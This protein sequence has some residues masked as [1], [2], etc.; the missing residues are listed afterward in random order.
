MKNRKNNLY[1]ILFITFLFSF[2]G[3][4]LYF[5]NSRDDVTKE[6]IINNDISPYQLLEINKEGLYPNSYIMAFVT[7]IVDGDTIVV[8]YKKSEHRV[9]L[10][11][12]D[13]P[14]S[15]KQGV[16]VQP[17]AKDALQFTKNKLIKKQVKLVFEKSLKDKYDRLLA[18]VFLTRNEYFNALLVELGY[19]R[20]E[21]LKPNDT[22]KDYF[23][24]RQNHAIQAKLGVWSLNAEK[25][26]FV[27]NNYGEYVPRYW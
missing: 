2:V 10:L 3:I 14:E 23:Y 11:D 22:Y 21:V 15:V 6:I 20:M 19:A 18:H 9:R 8:K 4:I 26:P 17:Y 12:I 25:N 27:K 1:R 16:P 24:K 13:T 5:Y 7:R